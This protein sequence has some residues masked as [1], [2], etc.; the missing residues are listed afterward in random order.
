VEE[1]RIGTRERELA[2]GVLDEHHRDGRLSTTEYNLRSASAASAR[3]RSELDAL[4]G[5]L[6]EPHPV[7]PGD[8]VA[9]AEPAVATRAPERGEDDLPELVLPTGAALARHVGTLSVFTPVIA[10]GLFALTGF[11]FPL[12]FLLVPVALG[13]L[14]WLG[15]RH[16]G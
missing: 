16:G 5:D 14:G 13:V 3:V 8:T 9:A 4:F 6:P 12:I 11:R 7:Y 1:R 10:F 2:M 15:H